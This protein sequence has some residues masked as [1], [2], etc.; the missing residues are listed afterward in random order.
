MYGPGMFSILVGQ[1]LFVAALAG[2]KVLSGVGSMAAA[3]WRWMVGSAEVVCA[4]ADAPQSRERP[5]PRQA[6]RRGRIRKEV[7]RKRRE[8]Q[9]DV[10]AVAGGPLAFHMAWRIT[11]SLRATATLARLNPDALASRS[12]QAFKVEN[13]FPRV[14]MTFAAS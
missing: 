2:L 10:A 9:A 6:S 1:C 3:C 13:L 12:P 4:V 5:D 14:G 8:D 11:P 7:K